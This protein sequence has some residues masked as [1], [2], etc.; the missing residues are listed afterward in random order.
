MQVREHGI[1]IAYFKR[2][3]RAV[4]HESPL[5]KNLPTRGICAW[6]HHGG[7]YSGGTEIPPPALFRQTILITISNTTDS[8]NEVR[9]QSV[10]HENETTVWESMRKNGPG[11]LLLQILLLAFVF[12]SCDEHFLP[13]E[14][15]LPTKLGY[16]VRMTLKTPCGRACR[17]HLFFRWIF[18][19]RIGWRHELEQKNK[20]RPTARKIYI[21]CSQFGAL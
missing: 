19:R 14:L 20:F 9:I 16:I 2:V 4:I 17:K 12:G 15:T 6:P 5:N 3:S 18:V 10:H 7:G 8:G 13:T 21:L 1:R 11:S